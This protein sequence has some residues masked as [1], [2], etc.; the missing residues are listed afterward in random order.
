MEKSREELA[1][2]YSLLYS[3][4]YDLVNELANEQEGNWKLTQLDLLRRM[5]GQVT[6]E[7]TEI[8]EKLR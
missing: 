8:E 3:E 1:D 7:L 4:G 5:L 2:V 6:I